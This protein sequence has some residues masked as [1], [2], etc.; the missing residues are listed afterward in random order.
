[1]GAIDS[2]LIYTSKNSA[3]FGY[4]HIDRDGNGATPNS[5][6]WTFQDADENVINSR[7]EV[8][9]TPGSTN[10]IDFDADDL[11]ITANEDD[12]PGFVYRY[13]TVYG[14]C[15]EYRDEVLLSDQ[16][17][18]QQFRVKVYPYNTIEEPD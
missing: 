17:Y 12:S 7:K 1:M 16:A 13:I 18:R 10:W 5:F 8:S 6:N 9:G 14:T 3:S 4:Q 15:D 2:E 11:T